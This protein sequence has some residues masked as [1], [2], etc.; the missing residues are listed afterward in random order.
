[1][2][3]DNLHFGPRVPVT[4]ETTERHRAALTARL[5]EGP[6]AD[7]PQG[8]VLEFF[9]AEEMATVLEAAANQGFEKVRIDMTRE[10]AVRMAAFLRRGVLLGA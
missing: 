3:Q 8:P 2:S 9:Q 5:R 6:L 7:A 4:P 10:D 1:M